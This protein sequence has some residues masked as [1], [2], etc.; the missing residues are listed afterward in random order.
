MIAGVMFASGLAALTAS[1]HLLN[2][3]DHII[4]HMDLYGG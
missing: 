3:G 2:S 4:T 1:V